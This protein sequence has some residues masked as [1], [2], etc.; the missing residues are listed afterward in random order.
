LLSV[1][2][3]A[4]TLPRRALF[5]A[6]MVLVF[7][8]GSAAPAR[9]EWFIT[10]FIGVKFAGSTNFPD[11]EQGASNT[12]LT[13]GGAAGVV[14][15]GIFGAETELGYSPRFFERANG[16]LIARSNVLTLMGNAII[17]APRALTGYSLRPFVSGGG[18]LIH[19]GIQ[20]VANIL[21]VSE[22]LFGV[23]VGGGAVGV[24]TPR[25]SVR[26]DLRFFKSVTKG[27]AEN[28]IVAGPGISFWRA[29]VG[30]AIR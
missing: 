13:L 5:I 10:P 21:S 24:L 8:A 14:S 18:G 28:M 7:M 3:A 22:N 16:S 26:F 19:V 17:T 11:L 6:A 29:S 25:T 9:A 27:D 15:E 30:L 23:N 12:K 2:K 1:A 20:D 4:D